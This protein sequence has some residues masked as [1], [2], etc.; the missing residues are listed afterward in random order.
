MAD[1]NMYIANLD[2][3][4]NYDDGTSNDEIE[5][6]IYKAA[7]QI[8]GGTH[9]DRRMGGS[10]QEIEQE[11]VST[12]DVVM[13]QFLTNMI[14]SIYIVNEEKNFSPYIVMGFTDFETEI[15]D[16]SFYIIMYYRLLENLNQVGQAKV[17]L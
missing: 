9:Y 17:Q 16:T 14:A 2:F 15:K 6:E 3:F 4:L 13:L 8:K 7:F 12:R 11:S 1:E 5:F 10:L